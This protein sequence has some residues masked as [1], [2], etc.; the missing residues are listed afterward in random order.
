MNLKDANNPVAGNVERL[1]DEKGLKRKA[2][3][4]RLGMSEGTFSRMLNGR[5]IIKPIHI[6]AMAAALGVSPNE[7]FET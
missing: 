2:V 3:A 5:A 4:N 6:Q 1:I 7:L